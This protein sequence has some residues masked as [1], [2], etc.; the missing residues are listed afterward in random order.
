MSNSCRRRGWLPIAALAAIGMAFSLPAVAQTDEDAGQAAEDD[1]MVEEIVVTATYRDTDLMDT[2]L[3]ISEPVVVSQYAGLKSGGTLTSPAATSI[4]AE[5]VTALLREIGARRRVNVLF[6]NPQSMFDG[7]QAGFV[8]VSAGNLS[9]RRRDLVVWGR[10]LIRFSRV[11]DSRIVENADFGPGWRLALVSEL[12]PGGDGLV[13]VDGSGGRHDFRRLPDGSYVGTVPEHDGVG[14]TISGNEAMWTRDGKLT[15]RYYRHASD[16]PFLIASK[17]FGSGA[18]F[19]YEYED[20][21]LMSLHVQQGV[22][23]QI[24]RNDS[25]TID[26]VTDRDGRSVSYVYD[27]NGRLQT[28]RDVA[29]NDW[30]YDY[31]EGGLL[32][33]ATGPNGKMVLRARY[34]QDGKVAESQTG[35]TYS[36]SYSPKKTIVTEDG[37]Q[38]FT[39]EHDDRGA[40]I[41]L[42]TSGGISWRIAFDNQRRV[43]ELVRPDSSYSFTYGSSGGLSSIVERFPVDMRPIASELDLDTNGPQVASE[44]HYDTKGR[45]V[46]NSSYGGMVHTSVDYADGF[47][48]LTRSDGRL[49]EYAYSKHG[50]I[51]H[52]GDGEDTLISAEYD[53]A[54]SPLAFYSGP[55][56]VQFNRDSVGRVLS[57][58]YV[59]GSVNRYIA[60]TN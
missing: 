57:L 38:S 59:G 52:I 29:G 44:F 27:Q 28:V 22:A 15:R 58:R 30:E 20:S 13:Y 9:F 3:T 21:A 54:G 60:T 49:F 6:P 43:R 33:A 5:T 2:P 23:V 16:R 53:N 48:R 55:D 7:L 51:L 12:L 50:N 11:Y 17:L 8:N 36:F 1:P 56:S 37:G 14:I 18:F 45:L 19:Q 42:R 24:A 40:T 10:E 34:N 35:R 39:F 47:V 32:L 26:R 41:A 4:D 31:G 25:G 46:D